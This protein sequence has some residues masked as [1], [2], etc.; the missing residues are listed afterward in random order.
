MNLY[1]RLGDVKGD[2]AGLQSAVTAGTDT[3]YLRD[4]ADASRAFDADC[5]GRHFYAYRATRYFTGDGTRTLYLP[6]DLISVST[7]TVDTN[8]DGI[9]DLMLVEGTD[10]W[11]RPDSAAQRG[12]PYWQIDLI[13]RGVQLSYWPG[14]DRAIAITGLWGW[15]YELEST[16]LTGTLADAT[17]TSLVADAT[18]SA[19]AV[20]SATRDVSVASASVPVTPVLS[21]SYD[22]PHNPVMAMA[23]SSPGQ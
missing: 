6:H 4:I 5:N 16:G 12:N 19:L 3:S 15:S 13:P 23:R 9:A 1:A 22:Q 17:D 18:A 10:Y 8:A 14:D 2:V 7:L 21:S 11:L 20:A